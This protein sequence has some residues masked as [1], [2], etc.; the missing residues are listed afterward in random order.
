M[1]ASP[2]AC[3]T[4]R[5]LGGTRTVTGSRFLLDR[6]ESAAPGARFRLL[7]D[8]GLFQGRKELRLANW[9]PFAVPPASIDAV[10][11]TH[12]HIDHSGYLPALGRNGF[13]GPIY[14]TPD[15]IELCRI[16]LADAAHL[17][18]ED[19]RY[20]NR[21][22]YSK[23]TP[24][25]PLFTSADAA[26]LMTQFQPVDYH[27]SRELGSDVRITLQPAGHIL[28]S[29]SVLAEVGREPGRRVLVSGDLGRSNHPLLRP[30]PAPPDADVIL[31]ESTYGDRLHPSADSEIEELVTAITDTARRGGMVV[32]PAFAVDRTEV[33]L[34]T[35][36]Q[37]MSSGRIPR[38]PI[39]VDSP[40]ALR[41]LDVYRKAADTAD[42]QLRESAWRSLALDA[43]Q[44]HECP[45][46]QQSIALNEL[47]YPSIIISASGMA[48]GGRVLHHL[49]RLLP[50]PDNCVLLTGFQAAGTRG[51]SLADGATSVKMFGHYVPVRAG[52]HVIEGFSVHADAGEI[53]EWLRRAPKPPETCYVV[54]GEEQASKALRRRIETNLGWTTVVPRQGEIVRL[55]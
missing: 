19:A 17:Q 29:A 22:G 37:L 53:T 1:S 23:H 34:H 4:L 52:V 50:D 48:T 44:I 8:C 28:G 15:T 10:V 33:V 2:S 20:A 41:V 12:A 54:H 35:L 46:P 21:K 3:P 30:A 9:A 51:R 45:T 25:L 6:P 43:D 55:D 26:A 32:I 47:T 31:V 49:A 42:P 40:M 16:L 27:V 24:A 14:A 11:L 5:F 36:F 18:E 7:V 38:L 13:R 39:H